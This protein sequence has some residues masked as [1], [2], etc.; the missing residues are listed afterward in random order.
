MATKSK[1]KSRRSGGFSLT[2]FVAG[3]VVGC[4][5][6]ILVAAVTF[7]ILDEYQPDT[8]AFPDIDASP[9]QYEYEFPDILEST[10]QHSA[11]AAPVQELVAVEEQPE[12]TS[13]QASS[14]AE[15][16][17]ESFLLQAGSFEQQRH[18]DVFR[19][20]LMLRGYQAKTTVIDVPELG[21]RYRVVIGPYGTQAEAE[22][23]ISQLA[24]ENVDA[25]LLGVRG[26]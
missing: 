7:P 11:S 1:A 6:L 8:A 9:A 17:I 21:A 13:E 18:A 4:L 24:N 16:T 3:F 15:P 25:I 2:S 26:T 10:R 20:S 19:A 22:Q 14:P 23:A 12:S 5:V